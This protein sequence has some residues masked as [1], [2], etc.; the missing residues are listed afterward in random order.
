MRERLANLLF[1]SPKV[2]YTDPGIAMIENEVIAQ[3]QEGISQGYIA[4]DPAPV[5][6]VPAAAD[7]DSADKSDRILRNV[8]FTA[9]LQGAIHK[10]VVT[11]VLSS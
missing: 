5:V 1:Q 7:V 8:N 2:P 9:T 6:T 11:G 4:A 10:I 3:L